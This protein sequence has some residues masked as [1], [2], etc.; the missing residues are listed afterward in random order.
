MKKFCFTLAASTLTLLAGCAGYGGA[1][2]SYPYGGIPQVAGPAGNAWG[3]V[4]GAVINTIIQS[5][6]ASVLNGQIGSQIVPSDQ[7]FRL[8]QLGNSLQSGTFTELQQWT[9]PQTGNRVSL[10]PLTQQASADP[11]SG[12]QC[13]D[14]EE[15]FTLQ[16]GR[17]I[18]EARRA[19]QDQTGK[20]VLT[21]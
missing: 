7:S 4:E 11:I 21:Q 13:R 8:Q 3:G 20:W 19:C 16:D 17:T 6:A 1:Y 10:K 9:N 12:Q 18:R 5:M 2:P 15:V 14:L